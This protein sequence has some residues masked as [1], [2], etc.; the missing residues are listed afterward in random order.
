M[1]A[2]VVQGKCAPTIQSSIMVIWSNLLNQI[3]HGCCNLQPVALPSEME[4]VGGPPAAAK[5]LRRQGAI[6]AAARIRQGKQPRDANDGSYQH[7]TECTC[8]HLLLW[9]KEFTLMDGPGID[10]RAPPLQQPPNLIGSHFA[11]S[12]RLLWR[13]YEPWTQ[14]LL[15]A[16]ASLP[17]NWACPCL[18]PRLE[19]R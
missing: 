15:V 2:Q 6:N 9:E 11:L 18:T 17:N 16:N 4:E 10:R 12:Y 7:A 3:T 1:Q 19:A 14:R 5:T 13:P 8:T